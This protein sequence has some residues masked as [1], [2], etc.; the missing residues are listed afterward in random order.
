MPPDTSL[1]LDVADVLGIAHPAIVEKDYYAIQLLKI[2]STLK[3]PGYTFVFA[4]G[5]C[6][7][8]VHQ[9]TWRMSEDIDI[10]LD[11]NEK[12]LSLSREKQRQL[13]RKVHQ[14]IIK[15]IQESELFKI[16]GRPKKRNE[17]RFQQF[18]I[19]YPTHHASFEALRPHLQLEL[20]E[21]SL[22]QDPVI[23]PLQSLYAEVAGLAHEVEQFVCVA[24]ETTAA[25][26]FVSLLR[27]TAVVARNPERSDDPALIRHIYD[28]HL[29]MKQEP[30]S[31]IIK[32]LVRQV[33][34]I[35]IKQFGNQHLEFK[36]KPTAELL[37]G[38]EQLKL[39][40]VHQ[41]R[42]KA[43]IGPL[44]YHPEPANWHTAFTSLQK[45]VNTILGNGDSVR[46]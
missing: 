46:Q 14:K 41:Q 42:Y 23:S 34:K 35:D 30:D 21:S 12:T 13:R 17:G 26:K 38:F 44:V 19:Q 43:F 7:A 31:K 36:N 25:E 1:F 33:I 40:P 39:D 37:F 15:L 10:K 24:V 18:L 5:T 2:L 27:R 20:T 32:N 8:K 29:I 3:L 11:P 28:L 6:L 4:G 22:L 9:N 16:D 45:M